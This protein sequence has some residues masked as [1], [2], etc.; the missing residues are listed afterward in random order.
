[1]RF[2][3]AETDISDECRVFA[4]LTNI[5][6]KSYIANNV[7]HEP[8]ARWRHTNILPKSYIVNNVMHDS[9]ARFGRGFNAYFIHSAP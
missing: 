8:C 5:L 4:S 6:P 7:K 3:T 9:C 1:M 2:E